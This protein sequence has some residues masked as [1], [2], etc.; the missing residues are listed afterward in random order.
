MALIIGLTGS[1]ASGKST[2]SAML[3]DYRIPVVDADQISRDVVRPGEKAYQQ[4]V[5]IF[6]DDILL[7]DKSLNRKK[8][9]A[10]IFPDKEKRIQ[11]NEIVHP[12][13]RGNMLKQREA[14]VDAG[15]KCVVLDIPLL[16]ESKL[17]HFVDRTLV[18]YVNRQT[19]LER[20][21]TRDDSS[22]ADANSRINSQI[23]LDEK[24]RMADAVIDNNGT[25]EHTKEQLTELL[26]SWKVI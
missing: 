25:Q 5:E 16:F 11:L 9:G 2:V 7:A 24:A 20:L 13:V 15:E 3:Q 6:G 10:I 14:Y 8:L 22:E 26:K 19:Q 12:A 1:I 18:V 23:P 4:I 17:T 21:M